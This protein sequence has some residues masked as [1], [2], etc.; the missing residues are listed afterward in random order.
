MRSAYNG[1][2]EKYLSIAGIIAVAHKLFWEPFKKNFILGIE[3]HSKRPLSSPGVARHGE[4]CGA[5]IGTLSALGLVIGRES[6]RRRNLNRGGVLCEYKLLA[7]V[8]SKRLTLL[9]ASYPANG[10][11]NLKKEE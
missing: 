7:G 2:R 10:A 11:Y 6:G 1:S 4:T 8:K 9:Q 3:N 5:I